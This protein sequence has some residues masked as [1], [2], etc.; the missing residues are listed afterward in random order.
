MNPDSASAYRQR[1]SLR[2]HDLS[3]YRE[4][5][6]DCDQARSIDPQDV[7]AIVHRATAYR[8]LEEY[9][10]AVQDA[11]AALKMEPNR[12]WAWEELE[13]IARGCGSPPQLTALD[14]LH[15]YIEEN[16][17]AFTTFT[18]SLANIILIRAR[19][20]ANGDD[21]E[22]MN[23]D[24]DAVR[25][26][27]P[28]SAKILRGCGRLQKAAGNLELA[29]A[30]YTAALEQDPQ[31]AVSYN[32]RSVLQCRMQ[33]F[34]A[35]LQDS[36]RAIELDPQPFIY[37]HRAWPLIMLGRYEDAMADCNRALEQEPDNAT[38]MSRRAWARA[39]LGQ[40]E[41][42]VADAVSAVIM[43]PS[44]HWTWDRLRLCVR[45]VH[46][47]E[48]LSTLDNLH[49]RFEEDPERFSP[50]AE[51]LAEIDRIRAELREREETPQQRPADQSLVLESA[52]ESE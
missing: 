22:E 12:K 25:R 35:A 7:A 45:E 20:Y 21:V 19:L 43:E 15:Q 28:E 41:A 39:R 36:D 4:A 27:A 38:A 30:D 6:A 47:P 11:I 17:I 44:S 31:H 3:Q 50:H 40:M 37:S 52:D 34:E 24:C 13:R 9:E 33:N 46:D 10:P 48:H 2:I 8:M 1:A 26:L 5:I 42:A 29:I 16:P 18:E 49:Q 14:D 51:S 23:A 32:A